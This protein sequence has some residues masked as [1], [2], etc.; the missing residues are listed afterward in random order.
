MC[1]FDGHMLLPEVAHYNEGQYDAA[2]SDWDQEGHMVDLPINIDWRGEDRGG[3]GG[4][5]GKKRKVRRNGRE[6]QKKV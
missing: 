4:R 2:D 6:G 1:A 5:G 3:R